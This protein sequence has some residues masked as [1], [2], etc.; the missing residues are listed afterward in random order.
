MQ[1]HNLDAAKE[2]LYRRRS[3]QSSTSS[4][5]AESNKENMSPQTPSMD[6]CAI[7]PGKPKPFIA[8]SRA[9]PRTPNRQLVRSC[10]ASTTSRHSTPPTPVA[11]MTDPLKRRRPFTAPRVARTSCRPMIDLDRL[12]SQLSRLEVDVVALEDSFIEDAVEVRSSVDSDR[13]LSP[14]ESAGRRTASPPSESLLFRDTL[15][16][17]N[18]GS[19]DSNDHGS[20]RSVGWKPLQIEGRHESTLPSI[21]PLEDLFNLESD[22]SHATAP[23]SALVT[24][25][26]SHYASTSPVPLLSSV[27]R[28]L[29]GFASG[30]IQ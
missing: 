8:G 14:V 5:A 28:H 24:S 1:S 3:P 11:P 4:F 30:S 29:A 17:H 2:E 18:N 9:T 12:E 15:H 10:H 16:H 25:H 20:L 26:S 21:L 23:S 19:N 22:S 7:T 6:S 13:S 27:R